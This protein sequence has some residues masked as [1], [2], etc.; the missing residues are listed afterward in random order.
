MIPRYTPEEDAVI[1]AHYHRGSAH[2][3]AL[4]PHRSKRSIVNRA[5]HL[6]LERP[7]I[8]T[9]KER[10]A[11]ADAINESRRTKRAADPQKYRD[12]ER[13]I[14]ERAKQ[15]PWEDAYRFAAWC[16]EMLRPMRAFA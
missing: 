4:L 7:R 13:M 16:R 6:H 9:P 10:R 5:K 8:L 2:V 14:R 3:H 15:D 12:Y 1:R 11:R